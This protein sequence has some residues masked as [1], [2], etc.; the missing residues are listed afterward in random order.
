MRGNFVPASFAPDTIPLRLFRSVT[1]VRA[2]GLASGPKGKAERT[3]GGGGVVEVKAQPASPVALPP[4]DEERRGKGR[5][6]TGSAAHTRSLLVG[7]VGSEGKGQLRHLYS[8][9]SKKVRAQ[10]H[11]HRFR[12]APPPASP[13]KQPPSQPR[14]LAAPTEGRSPVAFASPAVPAGRR[15]QEAPGQ[16]LSGPSHFRG[17]RRV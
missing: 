13:R 4:P 2:P 15:V 7:G 16:E 17:A 14:T 8:R 5:S 1:C 11:R 9:R 10:T 12:N 3:R 6:E